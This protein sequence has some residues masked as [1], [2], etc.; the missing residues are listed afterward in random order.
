MTVVARASRRSFRGLDGLRALGALMVLT[1]HVGF[2]SGDSLNGPLRGVLSRMD[3]GV[4]IFFVISGFLL[5]RPHAVALVTGSRAPGARRYFWHRAVRILPPL[6]IAVLL[7]WLVTPASDRAAVGDYLRHVLLVQI[8]S[9]GHEAQALTQMWSLATEA[10]F[11]VVLPIA[12]W[13]LATRGGRHHT[14]ASRREVGLRLALLGLT[15][16]AGAA[17]MA[18]AAAGDHGIWGVWLPGYVGWFGLGMAL[19]LWQAAREGG[20]YGPGRAE[21]LARHPWTVWSVAAGV[22]LIATSPVAGPY[23]LSLATPG[24][25]ATKNLLYA[26]FGL[27]VVLPAVLTVRPQQEPEAVQALGGSLGKYLGDVSYGVFCYH[28][29]ALTLVER[30]T[31]QV[32]FGGHFWLLLGLTAP[33][34]LALASAS[35]YWLERPLMRRARRGDPVPPH[36]LEPAATAT[37]TATATAV[38][39]NS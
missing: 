1:T 28:L 2:Q 39:A 36:A 21:E 17:W 34:S 30:L 26:A 32:V 7:A 19:S 23:D 18:V 25:A 38:N 11:Y 31:G 13:L 24:Q 22:Y 5:Y 14:R 3:S 29:V 37:A 27:L 4:A 8:Y 20:L 9:P 15:P 12:A 6:W 10:A 33:L 16:I 35:F